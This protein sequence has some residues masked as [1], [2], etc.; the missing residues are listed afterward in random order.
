MGAAAPGGQAGQQ[1]G[2]ALTAVGS[3]HWLLTLV[4]AHHWFLTPVEPAFLPRWL[5]P[6]LASPS[7]WLLPSCG[8]AHSPRWLRPLLGSPPHRLGPPTFL[9]GSSHRLGPPTRLTGS[10]H[11]MDPSDWLL[12]YFGPA[13]F[14]N[15]LLLL[16]GSHPQAPPMTG[17]PPLGSSHPVGPPTFPTGSSHWLGATGRFR[18]RMRMRGGKGGE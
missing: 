16:V 4:E 5:R 6:L 3:S 1:W 9:I 2:A 13:H 17:V 10:T 14:P 8:P 18:D 11:Y 15:W 7:Y 12:S